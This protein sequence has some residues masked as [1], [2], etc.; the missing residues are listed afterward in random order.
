MSLPPCTV[1]A[2]I[3]QYA[4]QRP[5]A[6]YA[7]DADGDRQLIFQNLAQSCRWVNALLRGHGL[8]PGDTV[9]LVM[10]N[11]LMTLQLLLGA[12]HGGWC[13]NPVN[14]LSQPD[15]M[16]Y[17]LEHS[18]CKLVF[19]SPVWVSKVRDILVKLDR[20]VVVVEMAPDATRWPNP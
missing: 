14:L 6:V 11:G 15:Q 8:V 17:V 3:E 7:I 19:V 20:G 10:P 4:K 2:L 9:S 13:V 16:R 12:M 5:D 1:Y 18:D